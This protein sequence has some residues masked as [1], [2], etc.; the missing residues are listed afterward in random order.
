[1]RRLFETLLSNIPASLLS[2]RLA[3][4]LDIAIV[5][6]LFYKLSAFVRETRA[7]TLIKGI[8][9]LLIFTWASNLL[10]LNTINYLLRNLMQFAFMAFIVVFQ[11]E[12][13][14]ALEKV[15]RANFSSLF[16]QEENNSAEF[17]ASEIAAAAVAMSSR[18]IGALIVL[19]RD[20]KI[21]DIVRTGCEIDSNVSSEL[22]INIFIPNTPL[23]DGAV[24]IRE[25]RIVAAR[26]ILPLT[27]NETLSREFGTRHRAALGLSESSDAAVIVVSEETG[28]ISFTLNGNMSR[29]YT[30][31]TLKKVI[32]KVLSSSAEKKSDNAIA[33]WKERL[34]WKK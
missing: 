2:L 24:I 31:D 26:C 30:E 25:N 27:H 23:H 1:M 12:L 17:I 14:R 4:I 28:K 5:A 32:L 10:Q 7:G 19:E 6:Y 8:I 16:T 11:P 21:G 18:R 3:D 20:T 9:L 34:K 22:L 13:R 15:G 29:N 33:K